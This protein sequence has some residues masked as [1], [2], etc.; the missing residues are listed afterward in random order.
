M[1]INANK[2]I[3]AMA[4]AKLSVGELSEKSGIGKNTIY[5]INRGNY[6]ATPK[7]VGLLA[8]ALGVDV[9]ELIEN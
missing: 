6:K 4:K 9:E 1:K 2:F 8:S 7:T 5:S 3:T